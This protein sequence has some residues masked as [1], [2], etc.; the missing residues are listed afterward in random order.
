MSAAKVKARNSECRK[1]DVKIV[2]LGWALAL[3]GIVIVVTIIGTVVVVAGFNRWDPREFIAP[4]N[5]FWDRSTNFSTLVVGV[6]AALIGAIGASVGTYF[7]AKRTAGEIADVSM[8]FQFDLMQREH[9]SRI[10]GESG[11]IFRI[12]GQ[13]FVRESRRL[14]D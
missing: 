9:V 13:E 3:A 7:V 6:F 11:D 8:R 12:P 10:L 14:R 2:S 4:E 1:P 5:G